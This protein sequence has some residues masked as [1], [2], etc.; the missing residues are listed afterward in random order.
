MT[1]E[2]VRNRNPNLTLQMGQWMKWNKPP[3]TK[4]DPQGI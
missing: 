3:S 2:Q 4:P 1:L